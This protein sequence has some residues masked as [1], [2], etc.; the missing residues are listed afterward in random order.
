MFESESINT[1]AA[2]INDYN[3][4]ILS[5]N[6]AYNPYSFKNTVL[7]NHKDDEI[8]GKTLNDIP[9]TEIFNEVD[10][11]YQSP[12]N[13]DNPTSDTLL[14][15]DRAKE[16]KQYKHENNLT[17]NKQRVINDLYFPDEINTAKPGLIS[18][19]G[20]KKHTAFSNRQP[21]DKIDA[22]QAFDAYQKQGGATPEDEK[23]SSI[24]NTN[25]HTQ[26]AYFTN[27]LSLKETLHPAEKSTTVKVTIGQIDVKAIQEVPPNLVKNKSQEAPRMSLD[28]YLKMRNTN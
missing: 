23:R 28:D 13:I 17:V 19:E 16:N 2:E 10:S 3:A 6:K 21:D 12:E 11:T 20:A 27:I 8:S 25:P 5:G 4:D 24:F 15:F 1:A 7:R 22:T 26:S 14:N 18:D 9:K